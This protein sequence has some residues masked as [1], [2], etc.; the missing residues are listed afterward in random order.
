MHRRR[1]DAARAA[2]ETYGWHPQERRAASEQA[3]GHADRPDVDLLVGTGGALY[4]VTAQYPAD[5]AQ[6]APGRRR[7]ESWPALNAARETR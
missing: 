4:C 5:R 6:G 2:L 1:Q 7:G 3:Y